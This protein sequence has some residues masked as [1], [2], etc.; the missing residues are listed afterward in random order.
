MAVRKRKRRVKAEVQVGSRGDH[1][2]SFVAFSLFVFLLLTIPSNGAGQTWD[3]SNL[4]LS[5]HL[6]YSFDTKTDDEILEDWFDLRYQTDPFSFGARFEAYQPSERSAGKGKNLPAD[7]SFQDIP[8]RF[9]EFQRDGIRVTAGNFYD[10][11]GRGI[12]FRSYENRDVRVDNNLDGIRVG[13]QRD[14]FDAKFLTGKMLNKNVSGI[15]QERFGLLHA[16]NFEAHLSDRYRIGPFQHFLVGSSVSR[17]SVSGLRNEIVTG[18]VEFGLEHLFFYGEYGD[19]NNS[20]GQAVYLGTNLDLFGV[21]LTLEYKEYEE[22]DF[23]NNPP[24]LTRE[25]TYT[26]LGRNAWQMNP[27]DEKGVQ[28]EASYMPVPMNTL[29]L[30]YSRT[31]NLDG[32]LKFEECY[33]EW[34][35]YQGDWLYM[36]VAYAD[37]INEHVRSF[38]PIVELEFFLDERNSFRTELQHQHQKGYFIGEFD[39][40]LLVLEYA[41]SPRWTLSFVGERNNLSDRQI[42]DQ[43]L[44][45]KNTFLSGQVSLQISQN[46][47][48]IAFFGSRQKG[49]VCV[50][51]VCRLEPEFEGIEV[52]LFSRF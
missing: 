24:A 52:K 33:G 3:F 47:E 48:M 31:T 44:P 21:G 45:D 42:G 46:H 20:N 35:R 16:A 7:S 9:L 2:E 15:P 28:I 19:R 4:N 38:I 12:A 29:L 22:F 8:F 43:N 18:R 6:E 14:I 40:D 34:S 25:H 49:K 27:N 41:R 30:N 26:L 39:V 10:I 11:F 36:V 5:N 1:L 23:H 37:Q 17:M 50:G 13:V 51:G 32:G